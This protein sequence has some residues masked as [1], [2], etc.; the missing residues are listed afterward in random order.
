[1]G[2]DSVQ[3]NPSVTSAWTASVNEDFQGTKR[4]QI[5]VAGE[6][7][8]KVL[9]STQ[10]KTREQLT[11]KDRFL[12]FIG[13]HAW[14]PVRLKLEG[15]S[16]VKEVFV[17]ADTVAN[18]L[19]CSVGTVRETPHKVIE[20]GLDKLRA[21][22][23]ARREKEIE[24]KIHAREAEIISKH[25]AAMSEKR[26]AHLIKQGFTSQQ[27]QM[28][29][30]MIK[31]N[32]RIWTIAAASVTGKKLHL[33]REIQG[34]KVAVHV[35]ST[36]EIYVEL[37]GDK[38]GTGAFKGV[39][40][41]IKWNSAELVAIAMSQPLDFDEEDLRALQSEGE[42]LRLLKNAPGVVRTH[43]I[44]TTM[45]EFGVIQ[46]GLMQELYEGDVHARIMK[47]KE[48]NVTLTPKEEVEAFTR[49]LKGTMGMAMGLHSVHAAGFIHH[50]VKPHNFLYRGDTVVIT[51]F[52][53]IAK[54]SEG[55]R[56]VT[57]GTMGYFPPEALR[58]Y[59]AT[60]QS[61]QERCLKSIG[62]PKDIWALGLTFLEDHFHF[63][64]DWMHKKGLSVDDM[65][66]E[67][68]ELHARLDKL[69]EKNPYKKPLV[70]LIKRMLSLEPQQRPTAAQ[71]LSEL[72]GIQNLIG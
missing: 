56:R 66:K 24:S 7:L 28:L 30:Q 62:Q 25:H 13:K 64:P 2:E 48:A 22:D 60:D 44:T 37:P 5:R 26:D 70:N 21:K 45:S 53:T 50:D 29:Q 8:G 36:G 65:E 52:G 34:L 38:I 72:Q 19:F 67:L 68:P 35:F 32:A 47:E 4:L 11:F 14:V 27:S 23:V 17:K 6:P 10:I 15:K 39:G 51:D 55:Q 9:L 31:E 61:E 1:M 42:V 40:V 69:A 18:Q 43:E 57:D 49:K 63:L 46:Y 41:G 3:L 59:R 20:E 16:Q 12:A 71:V 54:R 33:H 58:A